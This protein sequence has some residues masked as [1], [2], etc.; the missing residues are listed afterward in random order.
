MAKFKVMQ[1]NCL[2]NNLKHVSYYFPSR[3]CNI[4]VI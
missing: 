2:N 1:N 3:D 4:Y